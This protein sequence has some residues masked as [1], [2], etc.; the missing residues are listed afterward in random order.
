VRSSLILISICALVVTAGCSRKQVSVS[1]PPGIAKRDNS[2]VDLQ[3]GWTIRVV[4]PLLKSGAVNPGLAAQKSNGNTISLTA[5]NLIGYTTA[6]YAVV[7]KKDA[8]V[9]LRFVSAEET[10]NAQTLPVS[11]AP[12][13]P[14]ALPEK[15]EHV[16]L[17]YLVRASQS[18]H[19]MAIAG[20]KRIEALN[21][22]TS[23]LNEDP[24]ACRVNGAIFCSWVPAGVAVRPENR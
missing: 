14:F 24:T 11:S 3:P 18:D 6:H 20:A 22:F 17:I 2:F 13:L 8:G 19:N 9:R 1:T 23:R 5:E 15:N 4:M 21:A 12:A 7:G 10:K 16:R